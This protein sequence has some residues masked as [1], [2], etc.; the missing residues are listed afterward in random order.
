MLIG[1]SIDEL[2]R[3]HP[4][5]K[6]AVFEGVR[7]ILGQ[8]EDLGKVFT[9]PEDI[10]HFYQLVPDPE[11]TQPTQD[12]GGV[13]MDVDQSPASVPA[14]SSED[15]NAQ[16]EEPE[17]EGASQKNP[18]SHDN[19]IVAFIDVV[20]RVPFSSITSGTVF[21]PTLVFGRTIPAPRTLQ[22]FRR[23]HRWSRTHRSSD[24]TALFT[25]RLCE[26]HRIRLSRASYSYNG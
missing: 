22:G 14:T 6:T 16:S 7:S 21:L 15:P 8:I 1:T 5:L 12:E 19:Q 24:R 4:F 26:Q 18:E 17:K 20:G 10:R 11:A 13:A 2:I 9:I 3:H 25:T 23:K